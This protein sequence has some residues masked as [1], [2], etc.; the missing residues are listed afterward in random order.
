[1]GILDEFKEN[2]IGD[3]GTLATR[4]FGGG[5][6]LVMAGRLLGYFV[7]LVFVADAG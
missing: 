4:G 6:G 1:M 7:R 3:S 2:V 5:R